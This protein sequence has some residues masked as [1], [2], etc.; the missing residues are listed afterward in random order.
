MAAM[1]HDRE[2]PSGDRLALRTLAFAGPAALLA[3]M[4]F[5]WIGARTNL[6][7]HVVFWDNLQWTVAYAAA[8]WIAWNGVASAPD[9]PTAGVRRA[10]VLGLVL[11]DVG[12]WIWNLQVPLDWLPFP[13]PSDAFFLSTGIAFAWGLWRY[14]RDM[15]SPEDW[16]AVRLDAVAVL[17]ACLAASMALFL[18]HRGTY[19]VFQ[20]IVM[21]A[22]AVCFMAPA[23]LGL[24]LTLATRARLG[25]RSL[26]LPLATA[27]LPVLWVLWNLR[28]LENRLVDGDWLN[29]SF[30]AVAILIGV[31]ASR[32]EL[33]PRRD[34]AWD[35][36]CEALLRLLPLALVTLATAGIV[37]ANMLPG[38]PLGTE[39]WA[40]AGGVMVVVLAAVRQ[41]LTLHERDRLRV[42]ER[43][44]RQRE[45]ELEQ[46]VERRTRELALAK[47]QAERANL[48]KS[49]FLANMSHE[50]R[51]PMNAIVGMTGLVLM[52][53]LTPR[54]RGFLEKGQDAAESLLGII[55]D[56]LDFSKVEAG[57]LQMEVQGFALRQVLDRVTVIVGQRAQEKGL[58]LHFDTAAD[59]PARLVGDALRLQQVLVNL[60]SN[61]V[62]FT[63][64]G[65]IVV[66]M[67]AIHA[68]AGRVTLSFSVRDTGVGMTREQID[69][70]FRPFQQLDAS[71]TR[72]H[73]G[74]G[75]GLAIS[76]QLVALMGGEIGVRSEPGQG[77]EFH[78]TA[79]FGVGTEAPVPTVPA[80]GQH[81]NH[82]A[83]RRV[84]LV[85]DG[86]VNRI[87]ATEMLR[88]TLGMIAVSASSGLEAL[89]QLDAES[90]DAVLMD[91][92]M[93]DMDGSEATRAIR[94]DGRWGDL[95]I[96]AITAHAMAGD[97]ER[98]LAAGM[99]AY[100]TKPVDVRELVAVLT[101]W[102]PR[103]EGL[104]LDAREVVGEGMPA[105]G[106]R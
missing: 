67:R 15:L 54:Q 3:L 85:E 66:A 106:P 83:G 75:L 2:S 79:E 43:L 40:M 50:I 59:V 93:P 1:S 96:I 61:A 6:G 25:P 62:K 56:I 32:F 48:A 80:E 27:V 13:G 64:K 26:G 47:E 16:T 90:F 28:F 53:E 76:R 49:E 10:Y 63:D 102:V 34:D 9:A 104:P 42:A 44:L 29:L 19:T 14:G 24:I 46:R 71:T 8:A 70:L 22:Y 87:V 11:L 31:A 41:T 100:L 68:A 82:L 52:T 86:E 12:Q 17:A 35:R 57:M 95:P 4:L 99:N 21:S 81:T 69:L 55:N 98:C 103:G 74:T 20:V 88:A 30:S 60:C 73:G 5:G 92:Q 39:L 72:R 77:S 94:A 37:L 84:L 97:R 91:V 36:R 58:D 78:F 33:T 65:E 45:T 89:A 51:T 38:V 101:R 23:S 18:P 7:G 105:H